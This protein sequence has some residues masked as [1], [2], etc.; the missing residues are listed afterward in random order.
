V[1]SD[2]GWPHFHLGLVHTIHGDKDE[3]GR[4]FAR[5]LEL[6]KDLSA[7]ERAEAEALVGRWEAASQI[8]EQSKEADVWSWY[9]LLRL[10][11]GDRAGYAATC[12]RLVERFRN[13]KASVH[14]VKAVVH[15]CSFGPT[16]LA[17][18]KPAIE[19]AMRVHRKENSA[20]TLVLLGMIH[21]RAGR[22]KESVESLNKAADLHAGV[23]DPFAALIFAMSQHK[24]GQVKE[25]QRW[26]DRAED[27]T[28]ARPPTDWQERMRLHLLRREAE[29]V[30]KGESG[31][32]VKA[33]K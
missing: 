16:A 15:V 7:R 33:Q 29:Q 28:A 23:V 2:S 4:A 11:Q 22:Y 27:E 26:F 19:L 30:L 8:F 1:D 10:Y 6:K 3:A 14:D 32:G 5:A 25:A 9:A 21:Y 17:D 24:L 18:F 20:L 31:V 12:A 13:V